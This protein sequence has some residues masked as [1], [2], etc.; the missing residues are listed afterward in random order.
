MKYKT[1]YGKYEVLGE[2]VAEDPF[3]CS[4]LGCKRCNKHC[5]SGVSTME[6]LEDGL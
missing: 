1:N 5:E 4:A 6:M 3:F 2:Y